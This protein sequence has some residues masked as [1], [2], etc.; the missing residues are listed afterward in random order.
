MR[1]VC[2]SPS[3]ARGRS[4]YGQQ[5]REERIQALE[6]KHPTLP[7]KPGLVEHQ[8]FEYIRHSPQGLIASVPSVSEAPT[9]G[10]DLGEA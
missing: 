10:R 1:P 5:R 3:V 2:S 9:K 6:R 4:A 7:M 8:E